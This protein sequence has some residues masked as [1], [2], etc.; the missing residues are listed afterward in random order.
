MQDNENAM[1]PA[2]NLQLIESMINRAKDKFS[3]NGHL[4]LL[5]GWTVL[6]CS[7]GHFILGKYIFNYASAS[8]V[9]MLTWIVLLYQ[10]V[11]LARHKR[12]SMVRTYTDDIV[13]YVWLVFVILMGLVFFVT[14]REMGKNFYQL[15]YPMLLIIYGVPTFLSGIILRFRPLVIGGIACWVLAIAS[16]FVAYEYHLLLLALAVVAA[17][18]VPGYA[19][20]SKYKSS[21]DG[22][23]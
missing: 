14:V 22:K 19:L 9:W 17:W 11:Y 21:N 4:Y 3:E 7:V 8:A 18:I 6:V 23:R 1:T 12:K 10:F 15:L 16:S 5:W 2:A 13:G 20:Q